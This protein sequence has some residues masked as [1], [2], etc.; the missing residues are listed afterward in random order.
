MGI[1]CPECKTENTSDSQFCKKCATPLPMTEDI[2]VTKTMETP[3]QD[4]KRGT[5]FAGRYEIIEELGSGGMGKVYRVEDTK[6]HEEIALKLIRPEVAAD[7]K[8]IDRFRNELTTARKI[9]HKNVCG[10]YDLGE[11]GG[12]HYITM[13]YVTGEDLKNFILRSRRLDTG[14]AIAITKQV[15]EGLSEAHRLGVVHR[16]LKSSNIMI[17]KTGNARIMDFGIARLHTTKGLT[18]KGIIIGT[19]EYM[20]PEQAEAKE[21]DHRSDIYSLGVIL[22]EMVTGQLPF[23]GDT[24]L[25][26]A[27]KHKGEMPKNPRE[28]NAQ[29][30]EDLSFLILKCLE[31]KKEDRYPGAEYVFSEL[32]QIE[33][34]IPTKERIKPRRKPVTSKEI[35]I[36]FG[37]RKFFLPA[38]ALTAVVVIAV[39]IWQFLPQ[40]DTIPIPTDKPSLAVMYFKNE[41]GEEGLDHWRSALSQ[42]LITDLSQSKH[43]HVLPIDKIFSLF[44]KLNLLDA[45]S[46]ATEDLRKLAE[47]G[48]VNHIFQA[49]LSKAGD[50]FRIDYSLQ[51]ADTLEILIAD[52]VQ[53]TGEES[54]PELVDELTQKIK[55]NFKLS[56]KQ[57][58]DDI[59]QNVG[60][61][62]TSSPEAFMYYSK[63]LEYYYDGDWQKAIET[64]E[65]AIDIDNDFA[66]AYRA[67]AIFYGSM[68]YST[69]RDE[70]W[71]K[72]MELSDRVSI[73]ERYLIQ[74]DMEAYKKLLEIYPDDYEGNLRLGS[75]YRGLEDWDKAIEHYKMILHVADESF[76]PGA[77]IGLARAYRAK[78]LL[79]EAKAILEDYLTNFADD[80]TIHFNLRSI[81]ISQRKFD[82]AISE[83]EKASNLDP[84]GWSGLGTRTS[85]YMDEFDKAEEYYKQAL[86][87]EDPSTRGGNMRRLYAVYLHQGRYKEAKSLIVQGIELA[88]KV[89]EA[90]W[91]FRRYLDL[92][93]I[94]SREGNYK[95]ALKECEKAQEIFGRQRSGLF[96]KGIIHLRMNQVEKALQTAVELKEFEE[97]TRNKKLIR[98]Y[99]NL[100][101]RIEF[102]REN[103]D[104]AIRY[105][106]DALDLLPCQLGQFDDHALFIDPLALSFYKKG[107]LERAREAYERLTF[108]TYGR[109][110]H[111][112][113][114]A[115]GF[116]M[117][118][119]I[120]EQMGWKGKA[121]ENYEKFLSLWKDADPG[122]AEVEDAR[123]RLAELK[124]Q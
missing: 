83:A 38:L 32:S 56:D 61:I 109:F 117:L 59:D 110:Y 82:L 45:R 1:K 76:P 106:E 37:L 50:I 8:T 20:S 88:K 60:K 91:E 77:H 95:E 22:F 34:R 49:S 108:L 10:M 53:G 71:K 107:D 104:K 47:E 99:Y 7:K 63:A 55:K 92:A 58:A 102:W 3:I 114:Y 90:S 86:Q 103:Y 105:F 13:E 68:S 115:K 6:A 73:R 18:D 122:I 44:R 123:E 80:G 113:I 119:K 26:I 93:E 12:T 9:R 118:G 67:V 31:K 30:P 51:K 43:I 4:L 62:T 70:Y 25:S 72:A 23:E 14:T 48:S 84:G 124:S 35:S 19:P 101:G 78:G 100:M 17:D 21:I 94:Y 66:M 111:G 54:F 116:H 112:D 81:Y 97:N 120:Y 11:H 42:W 98:Y 41:T 46:Y 29:I 96:K 64:C 39:I 16:D 5:I 33:E 52:Y 27:M 87:V 57:I 15:C 79:D 28:I 24:P 121:I 36:T 69:K 75:I 74:G 65:K 40:K 85:V 2:S 89:G